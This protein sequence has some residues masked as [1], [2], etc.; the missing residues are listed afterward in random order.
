LFQD[1][2]LAG[3]F[4]VQ[5]RR[6]F[7]VNVD[8]AQIHVLTKLEHSKFV[9]SCTFTSVT[10]KSRSNKKPRGYVMYPCTFGDAPVIRS[11]VIALFGFRVSPPGG[12]AKNQ[13]GPKFRHE[14]ANQGQRQKIISIIDVTDICNG[15]RSPSGGGT[16]GVPRTRTF[17][18]FQLCLELFEAYTSG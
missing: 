5:S 15:G 14:S 13:T 10:L 6:K 3:I 1:G 16:R 18:E 7:A 2:H 8:R 9:M 17:L 12:Q 11:G 4:K